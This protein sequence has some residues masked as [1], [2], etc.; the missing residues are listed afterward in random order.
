MRCEN[1]ESGSSRAVRA[2]AQA[3]VDERLSI[4]V[5]A[6]QGDRYHHGH[7][8][9]GPSEGSSAILQHVRRTVSHEKAAKA[10]TSPIHPALLAQTP[11]SGHGRNPVHYSDLGQRRYR[12]GSEWPNDRS[13]TIH[14]TVIRCGP[15]PSPDQATRTARLQHESHTARQGETPLGTAES[16][17]TP[18]SGTRGPQR[19]QLCRA[20]ETSLCALQPVIN[21][22]ATSEAYLR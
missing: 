17:M 13:R 18:R 8:G 22:H 11:A 2:D 21:S 1:T 3:P 9:C 10:L 7:G 19:R 4:G 6:V 15:S 20:R 14:D 12:A 16:W 5:V